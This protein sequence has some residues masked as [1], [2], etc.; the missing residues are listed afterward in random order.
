MTLAWFELAVVFYCTVAL[1]NILMLWRT[2]KRI[3]RRLLALYKSHQGHIR[4]HV[5]SLDRR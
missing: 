4:H 1:A 3:E 5:E 2:V